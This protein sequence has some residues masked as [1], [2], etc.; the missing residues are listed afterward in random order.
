MA[1]A[2]VGYSTAQ[3]AVVQTQAVNEGIYSIA[4]VVPFVMY[5]CMFLLLQVGYP[6]TKKALEQLHRD[7]GEA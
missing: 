5:L 6:L 1:L 2:A 3:D 7:L 4:T